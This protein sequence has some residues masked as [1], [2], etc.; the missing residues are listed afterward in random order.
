M[1]R[2]YI[3][4]FLML[5]FLDL[6]ALLFALHLNRRRG[7]PVRTARLISRALSLTC[8]AGTAANGANGVHVVLLLLSIVGMAF[9]CAAVCAAF[10]ER[11]Q[12]D[13]TH[14]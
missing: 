12:E 10:T 3:Y 7:P 2:V 8:I 5:V 13:G 4:E 11:K 14:E 1:D 9:S 6:A